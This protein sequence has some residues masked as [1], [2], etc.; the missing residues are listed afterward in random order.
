MK[1]TYGSTGSSIY[2]EQS[3]FDREE[4][5][6]PMTTLDRLV[7]DRNDGQCLFIKLDI[8]GAELDV[9]DGAAQVMS[10]VEFVFME[11]GVLEYNKGA[12]LFAETVQ[13]MAEKGFVVFDVCEHHRLSDII[14]FQIDVL[15][16]REG[17]PFLPKG[18]L[19]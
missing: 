8:H 10:N 13:R 15:F 4:Q 9:L 3:S 5:N 1:T 6:L 14:L 16:V 2:E 17:S 18:V 12:P 7:Q 11:V 19:F